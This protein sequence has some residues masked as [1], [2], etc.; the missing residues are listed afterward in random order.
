MNAAYPTRRCGWLL[1]V[2]CAA[3]LLA[4]ACWASEPT[5]DAVRWYKGNTHGHTVWSDGDELQGV[6]VHWF[7]SH[8]Y[9]LLALSDHDVLMQG[10]RW[11]PIT[12][13]ESEEDTVLPVSIEN[14][15]RQLGKDW[16]A[17]RNKGKRR[18]VKLKTFAELAAKFN[19]PGQFPH[20][21]QRRDY[22]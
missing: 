10:D 3:I 1:L 16:L 4:S 11:L 6:V 15:Q 14:A 8:G 2:P 5:G 18:E 9:Q 20:D 17:L 21:S 13:A 7:K 19:E 12:A 22:Q